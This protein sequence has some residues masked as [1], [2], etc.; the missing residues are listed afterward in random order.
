MFS[1]FDEQLPDRLARR[2]QQPLPGRRAQRRYAPQ[3]AYGRHFGQPA[4]D[5]RRAAVLVLLY[6]HERQW[7]LPLTLRPTHMVDHAGQVSFPGGMVETGES[8]EQCALRELQEELGVQPW[9]VK[10]LGQLTPVFVFA[11]N[12]WVTPCVGATNQRPDFRP[13][14]EEVAEVLEMEMAALLQ[15]GHRQTRIITYGGVRFATPCIAHENHCIWGATSMVLGELIEVLR[16]VQP[17]Q[18]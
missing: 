18:T 11:S 14:P 9:R 8:N 4:W 12:F 7:R 13:N 6:A 3:L 1:G 2:L 10:L 15:P 17:Q 16:E 5:T